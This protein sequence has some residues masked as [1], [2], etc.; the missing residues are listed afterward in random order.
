[1]FAFGRVFSFS[2]GHLMDGFWENTQQQ[3][4]NPASMSRRSLP[5]VSFANP[6]PET[7][8]FVRM[9]IGEE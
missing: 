9:A 7:C 4:E 1:M 6:T 5:F 3:G 2:E 8:L